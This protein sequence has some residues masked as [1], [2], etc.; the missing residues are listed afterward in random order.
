[1]P[2]H[3]KRKHRFN[4]QLVPY[5]RI[6]ASR[7]TAGANSQAHLDSS[8]YS[9]QQSGKAAVEICEQKYLEKGNNRQRK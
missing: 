8:S 2:E 4:F 6:G 1:M 7:F 5:Q 9:G 3:G